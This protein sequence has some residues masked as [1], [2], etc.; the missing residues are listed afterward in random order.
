MS[1]LNCGSKKKKKKFISWSK[2]KY[3][4]CDECECHY[5]DPILKFNYTSSEYHQCDTD[6]DGNKRDLSTERETRIKNW[7][8]DTINYTNKFSN[9]NVLDY[10]C[11]FGFFLSALN[12]DIKKFGIEESKFASK[13]IKK[14]YP[15]INILQGGIKKLNM[16]NKKFDV[17]MLY[18]VIEHVRNPGILIKNLK[19]KLKKNGTLIVGT[20]IVKTKLSNFFGKNFRH[21]IPAHRSLYN[22][23]E[24]KKVFLKNSLK[25]IRVEKPYFN[26]KYFNFKNIIRL[27]NPRKI[28]PP[29]RGSIVTIYGTNNN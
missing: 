27:F 9:I 17:I 28:S 10:G 12:K 5:Q 18:H 20:P 25:I 8:G 2:V 6:P 24:L 13:F 3:A 14:N 21:Y 7:Y 1:C 19:K 11:G 4:I 29:F 26:T 15:Q 22:L 16:I 23:R